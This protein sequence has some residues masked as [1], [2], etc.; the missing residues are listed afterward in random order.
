MD[1]LA[2]I[3]R[4]FPDLGL[5]P[6]ELEGESADTGWARGMLDR[7]FPALPPDEYTRYNRGGNLY[8]AEQRTAAN[9]NGQ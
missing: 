3:R 2:E 1:L 6:A 8:E 9:R 7:T 5:P 4:A